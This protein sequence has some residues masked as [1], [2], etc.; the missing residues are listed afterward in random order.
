MTILE[1][2]NKFN[3]LGHFCPQLINNP[4]IKARRFEQGLKPMIWSSLI[5]L[6]RDDYKDILRIALRIKTE[7]QKT[8]ARKED[9]K[10]FEFGETTKPKVKKT[11]DEAK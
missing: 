4:T 9:R 6:M 5:P 7:V 10:K 8:D 11:K 2:A 1:Y 3:K